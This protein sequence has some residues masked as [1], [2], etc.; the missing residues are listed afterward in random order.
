MAGDDGPSGS[1][2]VEAEE[3]AAHAV[4]DEGEDEDAPPKFTSA[5]LTQTFTIDASLDGLERR[6]LPIAIEEICDVPAPLAHQAAQLAGQILGEE[7]NVR[8]VS[9]WKAR[10]LRRLRDLLERSTSTQ[11]HSEEEQ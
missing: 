5:F 3:A 11:Q 8:S 2:C 9:Q 10:G 4:D 7:I 1:H 6:R